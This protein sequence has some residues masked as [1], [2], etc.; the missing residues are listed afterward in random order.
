MSW[1]ERILMGRIRFNFTLVLPVRQWTIPGLN[2]NLFQSWLFE[3]TWDVMLRFS[4][5]RAHTGHVLVPPSC[6][7]N[8]SVC[9]WL[10]LCL[11]GCLFVCACLCTAGQVEG[12]YF[13]AAGSVLVCMTYEPSR[14]QCS[15]TKLWCTAQKLKKE[16]LISNW[17]HQTV[18]LGTNTKGIEA[19]IRIK[20]KN[21]KMVIVNAWQSGIG[22]NMLTISGNLGKPPTDLEVGWATILLAFWFDLALVLAY[23]HNVQACFQPSGLRMN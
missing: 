22:R 6:H 14:K 10:F 17:C 7:C 21:G 15:L 18:Q 5:S 4:W 3:R 2:S 13:L 11:C 8:N 16:T 23:N 12:V 20:T 19:K 1:I 9:V